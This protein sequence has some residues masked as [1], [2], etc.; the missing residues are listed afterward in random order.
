MAALMP[1]TLLSTLETHDLTQKDVGLPPLSL[2]QWEVWVPRKQDQ[3]F[4]TYFSLLLYK[5]LGGYFSW[6]L[7]V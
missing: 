4:C 2:T 7:H 5:P 1:F 3:A 6:E